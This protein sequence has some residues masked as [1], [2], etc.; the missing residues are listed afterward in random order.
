MKINSFLGNSTDISGKKKALISRGLLLDVCITH[1]SHRIARF[2]DVLI[3]VLI[4][5]KFYK[6]F[7]GYFDLEKIFLDYKNK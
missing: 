6:L 3:S 4:F 7:F 1:V 5:S 2:M